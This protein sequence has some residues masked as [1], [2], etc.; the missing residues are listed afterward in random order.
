MRYG[1]I[2]SL[3]WAYVNGDVLELQAEDAKGD[4]DESNARLIPMVGKDLA[5]ILQRR[6][7]ARKVKTDDGTTLVALIFHHNGNP[8]V[9]IRK[10]WKTACKKA[11]VPGLLFHDLAAAR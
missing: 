6:K 2:R 9:D 8:I 4:R 5:G 10:A 7:N 3:K 11:G 1:E